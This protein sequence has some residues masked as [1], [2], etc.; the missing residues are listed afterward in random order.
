MSIRIIRHYFRTT[1]TQTA[2]PEPGKFLQII[3]LCGAHKQGDG[4]GAVVCGEIQNAPF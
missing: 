1:G 4:Q 3:S 2:L